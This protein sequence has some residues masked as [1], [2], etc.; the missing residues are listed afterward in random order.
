LDPTQNVF[1]GFQHSLQRKTQPGLGNRYP[2]TFEQVL[3]TWIRALPPDFSDLQIKLKKSNLDKKWLRA[4]TPA[5]LFIL[6]IEEMRSCSINYKSNTSKQSSEPNPVTAKLCKKAP[7][8]D[9]GQFPED[10]PTFDKLYA[11]VKEMVE[12]ND[13]RETVEAKFK[14]AYPYHVSCWLCRI[15]PNKKGSHK[16]NS[17]PLLKSLFLLIY[18]YE[19]LL[20]QLSCRVI[21][22]PLPSALP[23]LEALFDSGHLVEGWKNSKSMLKQIET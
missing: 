23:E 5:E 6:T 14:P 15:R 11:K 12:A 13:N 9:R 10:F 3:H 21:P 20:E 19:K 2:V 17:C 4:T 1:N 22:S 7:V 8:S 18:P 16:S